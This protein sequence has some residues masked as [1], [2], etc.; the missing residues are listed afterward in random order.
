VLRLLL[1]LLSLHELL[2]LLPLLHELERLRCVLLRLS[3]AGAGAVLLA[4]SLFFHDL[5]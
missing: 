2:L 4:A 1:L 3:C 5:L